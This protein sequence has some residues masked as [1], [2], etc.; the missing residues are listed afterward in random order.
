MSLAPPPG[1]GP[2]SDLDSV[3]SDG[4]ESETPNG[5]VADLKV[6]LNAIGSMPAPLTGKSKSSAHNAN[7]RF[8]NMNP[9]WDGK[10]MS[11]LQ[12]CLT[13][14]GL[15]KEKGERHVHGFAV[16]NLG[17]SRAPSVS[18]VAFPYSPSALSQGT[19]ITQ[20]TS[21]FG[22]L[23]TVSMNQYGVQAPVMNHYAGGILHSDHE[24]QIQS[25]VDELEDLNLQPQSVF[26]VFPKL[27][28]NNVFDR[29]FS[30][31]ATLEKSN[32]F[33]FAP[34]KA[35]YPLGS[36]PLKPLF[37]SWDTEVGKFAGDL[38]GIT[39]IAEGGHFLPNQQFPAVE[40]SPGLFPDIRDAVIAKLGSYAE[41][42]SVKI[43]ENLSWGLFLEF[44][45]QGCPMCLYEH[46]ISP[47][48]SLFVIL[49]CRIY[50]CIHV[51]H[52]ECFS[53]AKVGQQL[54][55]NR[56]HAHRGAKFSRL[57]LAVQSTQIPEVTAAGNH[58]RCNF[59]LTL[60][61]SLSE[62]S[63]VRLSSTTPIDSVRDIN[64][65]EYL[66]FYSADNPQVQPEKFKTSCGC[67]RF[68]SDSLVSDDNFE[69]DGS[70]NFLD[71]PALVKPGS[72]INHTVQAHSSS[73]SWTARLHI[74]VT[75][76]A[77]PEVVIAEASQADA[78]DVKSGF[79]SLEDV[80]KEAPVFAWSISKI[81]LEI[82]SMVSDPPVFKFA[83]SGSLLR[84]TSQPFVP[85]MGMPATHRYSNPSIQPFGNNKVD[86][87]QLV[88]HLSNIDRRR[89]I[90]EPD[91][92]MINFVVG[93]IADLAMSQC[94]SRFLQEKLAKGDLKYLK[95]IF[96]ESFEVFPQLMV[97]L[98]G[99]YFCQKLFDY[100]DES[101]LLQF[102]LKISNDIY[103]TSCDKQGTRA[104]QK[105]IEKAA[106]YP[107]IR[108]IILNNIDFI[109]DIGIICD[110]NGTHVV[111][112]ILT[113]FPVSETYGLFMICFANV[114]A[115]AN[116]QHGL[117][118]LKKCFSLANQYDSS[119]L[120]DLFEKTLPYVLEVC[121]GPY[122]NYL[123]Q[124]LMDLDNINFS[125]LYVHRCLRNYYCV[126]SRQKF[127]S[128]VV[129][130]IL[131]LVSCSSAFPSSEK[132]TI[133]EEIM[134]E[135]LDPTQIMGLLDNQYGN[136]VLQHALELAT[137]ANKKKLVDI[138]T[139][140][141]PNLKKGF[142]KRWAQ[143]I[144]SSA[145]GNS[146]ATSEFIPMDSYPNYNSTPRSFG[147]VNFES[148]A[149]VTPM[150]AS[151]G[152]VDQQS[153]IGP[154]NQQQLNYFENQPNRPQLNQF[155]SLFGNRSQAIE[156]H[157]R[158]Q[159]M[160]R[161]L[162]PTA[163]S[164]LFS[165]SGDQSNSLLRV[166]TNQG[167]RHFSLQSSTFS[168]PNVANLQNASVNLFAS[169]FANAG[170]SRSNVPQNFQ[171]N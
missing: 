36:A 107:Q 28:Q 114:V 16:S 103:N 90:N 19:G 67:V 161:N 50:G 141:L 62:T 59:N 4:S 163:S 109:R 73:Y 119:L 89:S 77:A 65:N 64:G 27:G 145:A 24:Q 68:R 49:K 74:I 11:S 22:A 101:Q 157:S 57:A 104:M 41:S 61:H 169:P 79:S 37:A 42:F 66:I 70:F 96:A 106:N 88:N 143:L 140:L 81:F 34:S 7:V 138:L 123:V 117:C 136:F 35:L 40:E 87:Q 3:C 44:R 113:L 6:N 17:G 69:F 153:N 86:V 110:P 9:V 72:I 130:K 146:N 80:D 137:P 91:D 102:V 134:H 105:L 76:I 31:S 45:S 97:N 55:L 164:E 166:P 133:R 39:S 170:T 33:G 53:D 132:A 71:N 30:G 25:L 155:D 168:P 32:G 8:A 29:P 167:S 121:N 124:H 125:C 135:L 118:V 60:F 152:F 94:G 15:G 160:F 129:E 111:L 26:G 84:S 58:R 165:N 85:S 127:S 46:S 120:L 131:R 14:N 92:Y 147:S 47:C 78:N 108:A 20:S 43:V 115:F 54:Q 93:R 1:F 38:G 148:H 10:S 82:S 23:S 150:N 171:Q 75:C 144:K 18:N 63:V 13:M 126:L 95:L 100:C 122:G 56:S 5:K 48:S 2:L 142:H 156:S 112:A 52:A 139:P 83:G 159:S 128:N 149:N 99:N 158:S 151:L 12:S 51:A 98:F 162:T 116:D 21:L 154:L